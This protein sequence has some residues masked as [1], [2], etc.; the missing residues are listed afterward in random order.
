MKI[1]VWIDSDED[2]GRIKDSCLDIYISIIRF[3]SS[4]LD[5]VY[6]KKIRVR[7]NKCIFHN[8]G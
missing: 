1:D 8:L 4:Y 5:V 2:L 7:L 6:S 3:E